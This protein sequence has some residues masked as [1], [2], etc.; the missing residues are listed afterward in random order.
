[1]ENRREYIDRLA[2]RLIE[3]ESE[4]LELEAIADKAIAEVKA[5]YHQQIKELFLKKEELQN[6][7]S[8]IKDA[9]GNAW[10]DMKAGAELSWE[11]FEDSVKSGKRKPS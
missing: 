8:K 10:E 4:I 11:V 3:L 6:K 7:A 1:M 2:A 5:E 9:S